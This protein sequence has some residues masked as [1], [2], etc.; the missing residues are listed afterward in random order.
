MSTEDSANSMLRR[1]RAIADFQFGKGAGDALFPGD[2][3]FLLSNTGRIRQVLHGDGRI[4]TV[5]AQDGRLTLG[6]SGARRLHAFLPPPAYR[7]VVQNDVAEFMA[8]G[9][10]A[11][12]KHVV[13]ADPE[14][15]AD[16][17]VLVVNESGD[18]L[19]TG[20]AM[21]SGR[22]MREFKYGVA[23]QVRKGSA[24]DVTQR[25]PEADEAD[26]EEARDAGRA[27]R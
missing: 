14:I 21:L 11:F 9:K 2:C 20:V 7:V 25:E 13:T 12:A 6:I 3:T 22:E 19:A 17:E 5:R 24:Q 1:V 16:E 18:L 4:A 27:D 23:V 10:N 26:D 8:K 15:R